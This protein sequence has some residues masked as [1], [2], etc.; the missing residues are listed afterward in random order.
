MTPPRFFL[1]CLGYPELRGSDGKIVRIRVKK[2]VALLVFLAVER[3]R[4][5][6]RS[7]LVS[8]LWPRVSA[9]KGRHSIS[10]AISLLRTTFGRDAF[11]PHRVGLRFHPAHLSLDLDRLESGRILGQDG[12]D[13][14][15][16]DGFL[17]G[18]DIDDAPEFALWKEREQARRLPSIHA[19]LLTLIDHGRRR[20]SHDEIMQRAERLLAIDHLAEEGIRAKMEALA[21]VGDR[22]SALRVFEEW[23]T[24]L[25]DELGAEPSMMVEGMAS[26][27]RKRGWEPKEPN[28]VPAVPAEQWRD[29]RFVGRKQEFRL[30]EVWE[31]VHQYRPEHFMIAGDSGVGKTTLAQRLV[32]AAG[33]E[34]ASVSRVQCYQM[35][36]RIPFGTIGALVAGLLGRPGV[37][38]TSPE[39]LAEVARIVPQ[40]KEHFGSLPAPKQAEGES[41]RLLFAEGVIDLLKAVMEERP[42]LLVIDDLHHAD[43]AS[44]AVLHL[45]MRRIAEGRLMVALTTRLEQGLAQPARRIIEASHDR[46]FT[47]LALDTMSSD[48]CDELLTNAL[49]DVDRH[50]T[51]P[52]RRAL[53]RSSRG[54][55]MVLELHARDWVANGRQCLALALKAITPEPSF[56]PVPAPDQ[57]AGLVERLLGEISHSARQVLCLAAVLGAHLG[58]LQAYS[59][60]DL[61]LAQTLDGM[62]E[63]L[64][65]R[66][67]RDVG[68]GLEFLNEL[69]RAHVYKSLPA[70]HRVALHSSVADHLLRKSSTND[71]ER[72]TKVTVGLEV[73]WHLTRGH[74]PGEAGP[75][76]LSGARQ[77]L[78]LGAPDDVVLAIQSCVTDLDGE[79][80]VEATILLV[81]ALHELARWQ[82]AL[83][84]SGPHEDD[85]L[86]PA[87]AI[88]AIEAR[89]QLRL[90]SD[91]EERRLVATLVEMARLRSAVSLRASK[92]A[93]FI[94]GRL[95]DDALMAEVLRAIPEASDLSGEQQAE[96]LLARAHLAYHT[97]QLE[98]GEA[99]ARQ[100]QAVLIELGAGDR[101]MA[102]AEIGLAVFRVAQCD[103][104]AAV[105]HLEQALRIT[106][107]IDNKT[108]GGVAGSN[109]ALVY[110]RLGRWHLAIERARSIPSE[111][112]PISLSNA[113]YAESIA[114]STIGRTE[115][116]IERIQ[117]QTNSQMPSQR[118][119]LQFLAFQQADI[120]WVCGKRHRAIE[121]AVDAARLGDFQA[122]TRGVTGQFARWAYI[123]ASS[124]AVPASDLVAFMESA[125]ETRSNLDLLDRY[126]TL[127]SAVAWRGPNWQQTIT[128]AK[129]LDEITPY[130]DAATIQFLR[131]FA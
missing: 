25:T 41:A 100:A 15:D 113:A 9:E 19:G 81:Q 12:V 74:R 124:D 31:A 123:L 122:L 42:V 32:T 85:E 63:L 99:A 26:Q 47:Q 59:I 97:R 52:E 118:W 111:A 80:R 116:A 20:G 54:F 34:G 62:A 82:D 120:F 39:G 30:Y 48:E 64:G 46:P 65:R 44:L 36:Q 108:L 93:A 114:L 11:P 14:L 121:R 56:G 95:R 43:E 1:K 2:H 112:D 102:S 94:A 86:H 50:P 55:P 23:K 21:L 58:D 106:N 98:E 115:E 3:R 8:L 57:Y 18:F 79:V 88:L 70:P 130:I 117:R 75:H 37:A 105:V 92:L 16:V 49:L 96:S 84:V 7:R 38:A 129:E 13:D 119:L 67:L 131:A 76:L 128:F 125:L 87:F 17:R 89:W 60:L 110:T 107:R 53:I 61:S 35:E 90:L 10:V 109:L 22:F 66:V 5:H 29:R 24:Q 27:L 69:V 40:V 127:R 78:L 45:V 103:Y 72:A 73:A 91:S 68:N 104:S 77:A 71:K 33:L 83:A 4:H 126:E 28:P 6:D 51:P 101:T